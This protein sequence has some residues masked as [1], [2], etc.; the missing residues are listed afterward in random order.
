MT[1]R[2]PLDDHVAAFELDADPAASRP[3]ADV[4]RRAAPP[5]R[6][7]DDFPGVGGE[8]DDPGG[9]LGRELVR[10]ALRTLELRVPHGRD[11]VPDMH[12]VAVVGIHRRTMTA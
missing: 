9:Y 8:G 11:V 6:V 4:E 2:E 5:E 12:Q 7:E 10:L 1:G 3:L